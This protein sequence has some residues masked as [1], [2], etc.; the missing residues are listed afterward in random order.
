MSFLHDPYWNFH[1]IQIG[2]GTKSNIRNFHVVSE[3]EMKIEGM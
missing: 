3:T 2:N 1:N